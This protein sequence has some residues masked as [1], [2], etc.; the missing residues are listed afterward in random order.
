M[1]NVGRHGVIRWRRVDVKRRIEAEF[2]KT[3]SEQ[4][5]GKLLRR[6][7]FSHISVRPRHPKH[8]AVAQEAHKKTLPPSLLASSLRLHATGLSKS[9]GKT[10]P[11]SASKAA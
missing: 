5:V 10:K 11:A 3:M 1:P 2:G 4:A 7:G 6:L 8:D 9:G